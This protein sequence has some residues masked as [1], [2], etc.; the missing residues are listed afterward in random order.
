MNSVRILVI[1]TIKNK[2]SLHEPIIDSICKY[3]NALTKEATKYK[4]YQK[5]QSYWDL[6]NP[7]KIITLSNCESN[8]DWLSWYMSN[9][10][11]KINNK[12]NLEIDTTVSHLLP[13]LI[14]NDIA[15]L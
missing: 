13:K 11:K 15:L 1:K 9:N 2:G 5:S 3:S 8:D 4:G 6:S 12:F 10:R 7:N 14:F